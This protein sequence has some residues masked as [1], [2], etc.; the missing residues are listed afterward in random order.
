MRF[1]IGETLCELLLQ[2]EDTLVVFGQL[3]VGDGVGVGLSE[4]FFLAL[5]GHLGIG[6]F[7][8]VFG[9]LLLRFLKDAFVFISDLL[10]LHA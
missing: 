10:S 8:L 7:P 6:N 1:A 3:A 5:L 9:I 4:Y 2:I